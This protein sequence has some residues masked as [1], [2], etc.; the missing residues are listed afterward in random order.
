MKKGKISCKYITKLDFTKNPNMW[1]KISQ[2]STQCKFLMVQFQR[3]VYIWDPVCWCFV[4]AI[5]KWVWKTLKKLPC[6]QATFWSTPHL[7]DHLDPWFLQQSLFKTST[8]LEQVTLLIVT[9]PDGKEG[10]R[11]SARRM[12]MLFCAVW[13]YLTFSAAQILREINF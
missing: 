12:L 10:R 4:S 7:Q 11:R 13:K 9:V 1:Q 6:E 8:C 3:T 5:R 2:I